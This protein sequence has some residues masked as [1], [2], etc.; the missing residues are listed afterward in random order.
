MAAGESFPLEI[1]D[2]LAGR[3]LDEIDLA[4]LR[5]EI[6]REDGAAQLAALG[7]RIADG[8]AARMERAELFGRLAAQQGDGRWT[9][10]Q[11][12]DAAG[13]SQAAVSKSL[14]GTAG[15]RA[16]AS[17]DGPPY[18]VGRMMGVAR[19]LART[20][21]GMVSER[22]A[23]KLYSGGIPA[24]AVTVVRLTE[25]L[26]K[27]LAGRTVPA[28]YREEMADICARLD[29]AGPLPPPPWLGRA[30]EEMILAQ[31]HQAA[32]LT[33]ALASAA[34]TARPPAV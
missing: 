21:K 34:K 14:A 1:P 8:N 11:I 22:T 9:H 31:H 29:D 19:H 4:D 33:R 25:L 20:R 24:T 16:L 27:D 18:L 15:S 2:S 7:A 10:Q 17:S 32:A 23:D 13:I 5:P 30:R 6:S 26:R 28:V 12:A 3:D